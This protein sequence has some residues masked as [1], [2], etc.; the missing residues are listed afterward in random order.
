MHAHHPPLLC[1]SF[2]PA[3][4][5]ALPRLP[6]DKELRTPPSLGTNRLS[7]SI[8]MTLL[9]QISSLTEAPP[10]GAP[11]RLRTQCVLPELPTTSARG[12]LGPGAGY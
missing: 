7:G 12:P 2:V 6:Q 3:Q 1:Q 11:P 4:L 5:Q 9:T 8:D 10:S